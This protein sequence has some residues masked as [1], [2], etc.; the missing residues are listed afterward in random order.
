MS[1]WQNITANPQ[2]SIAGVLIAV[3]TIAG[4]LSQQGVTLGNIGTGTVVTLI[5]ALATALLGLVARDPS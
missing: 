3:V 1:I 5:A 4:V 2:T